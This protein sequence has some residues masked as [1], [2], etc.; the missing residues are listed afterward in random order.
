MRYDL[1]EIKP[2]PFNH[3]W[4]V[5]FSKGDGQ[6]RVKTK[7]TPNNGLGFMHYPEWW[8]NEQAFNK[9]K[10]AMIKRHKKEIRLIERSLKALEKIQCPKP[11]NK[12]AK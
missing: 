6:D 11:H 7:I 4:E 10:K 9:L 8:S 1:I 5:H 2:N 12:K 3:I